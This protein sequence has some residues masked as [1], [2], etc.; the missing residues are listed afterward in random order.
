MTPLLEIEEKETRFAS[1]VFA[2]DDGFNAADDS[3]GEDA[4]E[5]EDLDDELDGEDF[6][7]DD[8]ALPT[9]DESEE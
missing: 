5:P 9:D 2:S 4:A 1:D 3:D 6:S 7:D 8:L